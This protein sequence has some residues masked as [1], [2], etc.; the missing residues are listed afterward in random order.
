MTDEVWLVINQSLTRFGATD[1]RGRV[2][3]EVQCH[4]HGHV[5]GREY[6]GHILVF[7][8]CGDPDLQCSREAV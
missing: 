1:R 3:L 7:N 8:S 4:D 6:V 5:D 2:R